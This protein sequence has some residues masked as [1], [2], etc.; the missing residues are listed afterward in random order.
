MRYLKYRWAEHR[1]DERADW[2]GSWWYFEVDS[3]G[4]PLR[5]V[6]RYDNG[7]GLRYSS[8]H[9]DDDFGALGQG[10]VADWDRLA[11]QEISAED[12]EA[13]WRSGPWYNVVV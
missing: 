11:D 9:P 3:D 2:G 8:D 1:A 12:F 10:R 6:E 13:A 5:Q 4:Y 7:I